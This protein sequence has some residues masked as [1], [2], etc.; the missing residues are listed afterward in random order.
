MVRDLEF[1]TPQLK[2]EHQYYPLLSKRRTVPIEIL[3][4]EEH[5]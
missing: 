4:T 2:R 5:T 1:E 3:I